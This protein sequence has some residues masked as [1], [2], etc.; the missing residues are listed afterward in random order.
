MSVPDTGKFISDFVKSV[1]DRG[2]S[3]INIPKSDSD[4]RPSAFDIR[5]SEA[6]VPEIHLFLRQTRRLPQKK[7][8][9][10]MVF[11]L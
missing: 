7:R 5:L 10:R 3:G 2:K 11:S 1:S 8:K 9:R 4:F 6:K